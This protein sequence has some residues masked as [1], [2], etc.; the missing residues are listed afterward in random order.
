MSIGL[1]VKSL[2]GN[3]KVANNLNNFGHSVSYHTTEAIE[4]D[5]AMSTTDRNSATPE[6]IDQSAELATG[7]ACDNCDENIETLSGGNTLHNAGGI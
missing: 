6:G 1:R 3:K 7:I 5:L 2:T 4:S